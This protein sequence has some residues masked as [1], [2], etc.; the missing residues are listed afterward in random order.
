MVSLRAVFCIVNSLFYIGY[1][2]LVDF[3]SQLSH[4]MMF[5]EVYTCVLI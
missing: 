1:L 2:I 3:V 5:K 4:T